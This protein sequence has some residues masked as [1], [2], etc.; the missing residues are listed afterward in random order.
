[1]KIY[2]AGKITGERNYLRNFENAEFGLRSKYRSLNAVILNPTVLPKGLE[3]H[4]YIHI[5]Y[6]MIDVANK[7]YFLPDW[8]ESKGATMEH[9]YAKGKGKVVGY[10]KK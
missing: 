5:C 3:H 2:I 4:E 1:M 9:E 6:A 7:V 10:F 8:K